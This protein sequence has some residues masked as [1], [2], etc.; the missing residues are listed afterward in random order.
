MT[1][2]WI[3]EDGIPV[4][5]GDV[6]KPPPGLMEI[7]LAT[8]VAPEKLTVLA[9]DRQGRIHDLNYL[10]PTNGV[11]ATILAGSEK[12]E[13]LN[14]LRAAIEEEA[15]PLA[16]QIE[17]KQ[18]R[19]SILRQGLSLIEQ[20]IVAT[21]APDVNPTPVGAIR[22]GVVYGDQCK[23]SFD[24]E[25]E[26]PGLSLSLEGHGL[27]PMPPGYGEVIHLEYRDGKPM[28]H[29]WADINQE[30][31]THSIDLSGAHESNRKGSAS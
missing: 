28:L 17:A 7:G 29:V 6:L 4:R 22:V 5:Q 13:A 2:P 11:T 12:S 18:S 10:T 26:Y 15:A 9:L 31:P 25:G 23:T 1:T 24:L 19:L 20:E 27:Y 30:D 8:A 14:Q 3:T 21:A 16:T